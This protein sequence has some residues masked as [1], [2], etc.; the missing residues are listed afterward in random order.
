MAADHSQNDLIVAPGAD[1]R[2]IRLSFPGIQTVRIDSHG[3]LV[4]SLPGGDVRQFKP[5]GYQEINGRKE[6]VDANF[7]ALG[8]KEIGF[9][10]APYDRSKPVID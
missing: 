9:Q 2:S 10:L 8:K 5:K 7:V 6:P 4:L 1:P 3:D